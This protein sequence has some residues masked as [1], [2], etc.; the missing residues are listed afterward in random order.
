MSIDN[1][2]MAVE[3][4]KGLPNHKL[5]KRRTKSSLAKTRGRESSLKRLKEIQNQ[6][7][8]LAKQMK[9]LEETK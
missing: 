7:E 8:K 5:E 2:D 1:A 4:D 9:E 6:Q 3:S